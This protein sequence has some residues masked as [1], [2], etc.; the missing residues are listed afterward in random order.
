MKCN[1]NL[2]ALTCGA[3]NG[4][5]GEDDVRG[6]LARRRDFRCR[7]GGGDLEQVQ[8]TADRARAGVD[9]RQQPRA[10]VA[11]N[12]RH[13]NLGQF[14]V[15][16]GEAH[17]RLAGLRRRDFRKHPV[18]RRQLLADEAHRGGWHGSAPATTAAAGE[19]AGRRSEVDEEKRGGA[20]NGVRTRRCR[21]RDAAAVQ[22]HAHEEMPIDVV[23]TAQRIPPPTSAA[24]DPREADDI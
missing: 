12:V 10:G 7:R 18:P 20:S 22:Q 9:A 11:D 6:A 13:Y 21:S 17:R 23:A 1:G 15:T 2:E 5:V 19:G 8:H 3:D 24:S 16:C 14:G 4:D